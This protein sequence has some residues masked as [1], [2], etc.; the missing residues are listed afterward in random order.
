MH[1][2]IESYNDRQA[3]T[4][5]RLFTGADL[6][7]VNYRGWPNSKNGDNLAPESPTFGPTGP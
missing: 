3:H 4:L 5:L 6:H 1:E 2:I 7:P